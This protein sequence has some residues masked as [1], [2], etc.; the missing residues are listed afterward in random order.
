MAAFKFFATYGNSQRVGISKC[1]FAF[2]LKITV[3]VLFEGLAIGKAVN[4]E[5]HVLYLG[6]TYK[7]L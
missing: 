1:I 4:F 2:E 5:L 6:I 3:F 7:L